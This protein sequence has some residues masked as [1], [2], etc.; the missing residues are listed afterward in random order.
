MYFICNHKTHS[1]QNTLQDTI[2][3]LERYCAIVCSSLKPNTYRVGQKSKLLILSKY[4]N[5][6]QLR[7]QEECEQIRTSTEK[8][9]HH[10]KYFY[11]TIVLC[12]NIL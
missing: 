1:K 4:V 5:T 10:V 7:R 12:L 2:V 6:L 3:I 9:E 11:V 8:M